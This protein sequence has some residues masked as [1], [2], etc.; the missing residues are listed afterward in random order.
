MNESVND[1]MDDS[2]ADT[3]AADVTMAEEVSDFYVYF[4]HKSSY[5]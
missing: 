2:T 1:T 3:T 5:Y 4:I